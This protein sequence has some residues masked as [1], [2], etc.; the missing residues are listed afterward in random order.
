MTDTTAITARRFSDLHPGFELVHAVEAAI[1]VSWLTLEL[2]AQERK[3]LPVVD[4]FVLRLSNRGVDKVADIAAVLGLDDDTIQAAVAQQLSAETVDYR[5]DYHGG[6]MVVLTPAGKRAVT[7]LATTT[8]KRAEQQQAFDRLVWEP[9]PHNASDLVTR[10]DAQSQG[11]ILLPSRRTHD[12]TA[13][14]VTARALNRILESQHRGSEIP[15]EVLTVED[16]TRQPRRFLPVI[17]LIFSATEFD[18]VRLSI[19]VDDSTTEEHDSALIELGGAERLGIRVET[20]IGEPELPSELR[21]QRV[22]HE[23]VRSLQRRADT[24]PSPDDAVAKHVDARQSDDST[25]ARAELAGLTVRSVP[26]F[27][28]R[29]LLAHAMEHASRRFLLATP[30]VS[31]SVVTDD[32]LDKLESLLRRRGLTAHI[33]YGLGQADSYHDAGAVKRLG[34]LARRFDNLTFSHIQDVHPG[35]L[36]FDDTWVN[37]SFSWLSYRGTPRRTYRKEEGTLVR[38]MDI[39][40]DRYTQYTELINMS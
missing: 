33:A 14:D 40:D 3:P 22:S 28:H 5:P 24:W 39:V 34:T 26:V 21:E 8:P 16:I 32:M 30:S 29:E 15:V 37:S 25:T 10:A 11:M 7:D 17:L 27:E 31:D 20:P 23:T 13:D 19:V 18:D 35:I 12:V 1:P 2:L 9:M 6:R 36:I 4:E 38:S